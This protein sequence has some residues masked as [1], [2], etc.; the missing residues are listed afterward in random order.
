MDILGYELEKAKEILK[1]AGYTNIF[2]SYTK[3]PYGQPESGLSATYRVLRISKLE[4]SSV[5]ILACYM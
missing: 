2:V 4:D 5:E 1:K 3:S